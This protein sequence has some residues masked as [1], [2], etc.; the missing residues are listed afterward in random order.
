M[1]VIN[2][3]CGKKKSLCP[4]HLYYIEEILFKAGMLN[5]RRGGLNWIIKDSHLE[6][7]TTSILMKEFISGSV[8]KNRTLVVI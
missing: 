8:L 3:M 5:I 1:Q 4:G 6:H 2:S 7:R